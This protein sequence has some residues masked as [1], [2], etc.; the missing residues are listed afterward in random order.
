MRKVL[1]TIDIKLNRVSIQL[2]EN[3]SR[4]F[5]EECQG[6]SSEGCDEECAL[7]QTFVEEYRI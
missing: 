2:E 3:D 6:N 4:L 7:E 1:V 5:R